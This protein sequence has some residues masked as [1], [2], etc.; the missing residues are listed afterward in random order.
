MR[1]W[2][3]YSWDL[4]AQDHFLIWSLLPLFLR[5]IIIV[6]SLLQSALRH[7]AAAAAVNPALITVEQK[8]V[9]PEVCLLLSY[10]LVSCLAQRT[11][12]STKHWES[13]CSIPTCKWRE[14]CCYYNDDQES[15]CQIPQSITDLPKARWSGLCS[16]G[17]LRAIKPAVYELPSSDKARKNSDSDMMQD[18]WNSSNMLH[19]FKD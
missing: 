10:P 8:R 5:D 16:A 2:R 17:Q 18:R 19:N 11:L 3:R 4:K 9:P 15:D 14:G 7:E 12:F 1:T 13:K 6:G